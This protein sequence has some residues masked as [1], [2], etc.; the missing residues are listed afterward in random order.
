MRWLGA[1]PPGDS[2]ACRDG[3]AI[4]AVG[5]NG[6]RLNLKKTAPAVAM[7]VSD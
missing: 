6:M 1:R 7:V 3:W 4:A 5:A 2:E